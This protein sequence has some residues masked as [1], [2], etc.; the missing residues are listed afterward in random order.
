MVALLLMLVLDLA[1]SIWLIRIM[2]RFRADPTD[3][4]NDRMVLALKRHELG[5]AAMDVLRSLP[6]DSALRLYLGKLVG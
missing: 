5:L 3:R 6:T 4:Q 2:K 1:W